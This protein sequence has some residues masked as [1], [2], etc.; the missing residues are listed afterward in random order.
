MIE[1]TTKDKLK[2][3]L[4]D[5]ETAPLIGFSWER[6][7][8]NLLEVVRDR[9]MLCFTV[10]W[11]DEKKYHTY[12][13]P[14]FPSY[15]KDKEN[16]KELVTKLWDFMNEADVIVGHYCDGFDVKVTNARFIVNGLLPPSTYRTVDT[17]K[18]A[19]KKFKFSS[20]KLD[21]L[22]HALGLGRKLSTGGFKLWK[23]CMEGKDAAWKKMTSY[24][25]M[26]V[27][28]LEKVYLKI[29][30]WIK[31]HP[32]IGILVDKLACHCCAS[33]NTQRRGYNYTKLTKYIR[34]L[35]KDCGS[36]SQGT[37]EKSNEQSVYPRK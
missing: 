2:I 35:C 8:T 5:I 26:D 36:W 1:P 6:Y 34:Y 23:E 4:L 16:D 12:S 15:L 24:N 7:D 37:M 20:N 27:T 31:N 29:R 3:L 18:E 22:G 21:D 25:K 19:K 17:L 9:Y 28:L 13:L 10:K 11:L 32:N 14:D 33:K 30:P